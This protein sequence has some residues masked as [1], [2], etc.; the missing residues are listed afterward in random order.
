VRPRPPSVHTRLAWLAVAACVLGL[1]CASSVS[2]AAP[3]QTLMSLPDNAV[4]APAATVPVSLTAAPATGLLSLDA[5]IEFNPAIINAVSVTKTAISQ[6]MSLTTNLATPGVAIISLFGAQPLSGSGA[7]L[8]ISFLVTGASNQVTPMTLVY[9][10]INEGSIP[11][12]LD[13]GVFT[14][15][16]SCSDGNPCTT[17]SCVPGVGCVNAPD[18]SSLPA[19]TTGL[20]VTTPQPSSVVWTAQPAGTRFDMVSGVLA[21]LRPQSGVAAGQCLANDLLTSSYSDVRPRPAAGSGVY[22]IVRSQNGCGSSTYGSNSSGLPRVPTA[23]C[24]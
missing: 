17:D 8:T 18:P 12:T 7:I 13:S 19:E 5:R 6:S 3:A 9:A 23:G 2:T 15:C 20:R 24:P 16:G 21:D 11:T 1:L 4:G 10:L 22:Y 14:V